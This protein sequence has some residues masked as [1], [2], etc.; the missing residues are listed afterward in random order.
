MST[1]G[2]L[3]PRPRTEPLQYLPVQWPRGSIL[4]LKARDDSLSIDLV[5][6]LERRQT[7]RDF[8]KGLSLETLGELLWL[9]CRS[10]SS[11]ASAL[12]F[13]LES[14]PHPS[15]GAIHPVHVLVSR[16]AGEPW[17]RYDAV[18]HA[19]VEV[20]RSEIHANAARA[21]ANEVVP[22]SHALLLGFVAEPGKTAA[23][24][25]APESLVWRDAGV[26]LGYLS[27]LA[28]A[29]ELSFCPLGITGDPHLAALGKQGQLHGAG[30]AL[31]GLS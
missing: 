18:E 24:Y 7:R 15:A 14:R 28:E 10:R 19:L 13:S 22:F 5:Q 16:E 1:A 20:P 12:G 29:M 26:L 2:R 23:K 31:I 8:A 3:S 30:M 6:L 25:E 21:A 27:L 9:S 17:F 4:P 11:R